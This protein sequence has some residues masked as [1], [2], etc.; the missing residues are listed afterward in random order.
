MLKLAKATGIAPVAKVPGNLSAMVAIK[1][2]RSCLRNTRLRNQKQ[3]ISAAAKIVAMA[4]LVTEAIKSC[5]SI[6][7][8]N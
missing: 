8:T 3:Y 1:E 2:A 4:S 5:N 6:N 7:I